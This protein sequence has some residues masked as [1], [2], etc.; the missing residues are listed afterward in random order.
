MLST[1]RSC[2]VTSHPKREKEH[3]LLS[4]L[5]LLLNSLPPLP[6]LW[7]NPVCTIFLKSI[8]PL[9]HQGVFLLRVTSSKVHLEQQMEKKKTMKSEA[10][11]IR[12]LILGKNKTELFPLRC[13]YFQLTIAIKY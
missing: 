9:S 6:N 4:S 12:T 5:P 7:F 1:E 13:Y 10:K 3:C 2:Y 8:S 11:S